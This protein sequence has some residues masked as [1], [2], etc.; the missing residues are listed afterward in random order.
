MS[1]VLEQ[2]KKSKIESIRKRGESFNE[3]YLY[4]PYCAHEQEEIWDGFDLQPNGEE[5]EGECQSCGRFFFYSVDLM[6]CTRKAK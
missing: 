4:C 3:A 1:D 2:I 6:F 5:R